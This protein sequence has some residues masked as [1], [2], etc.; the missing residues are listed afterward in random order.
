MISESRF[1][2]IDVWER[3]PV[4]ER[5]YVVVSYYRPEYYSYPNKVW[6]ATFR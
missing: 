2:Q 4:G 6:S 1:V 5:Y 3:L